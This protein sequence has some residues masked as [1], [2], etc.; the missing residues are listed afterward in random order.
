MPTL[1]DVDSDFGDPPLMLTLAHVTFTQSPEIMERITHVKAG[2]SELGLP[3][4]QTKHQS[5]I[6]LNPLAG[7]APTLRQSTFWWFSNLEKTRAVVVAAN[8]IVLYDANYGRFDDFID[9]IGKICA[10]VVD[11]AGAGCF[12]TSV[13]LRY[14]SGCAS[15]GAPSPY[16][17]ESLRGLVTDPLKIEHFHHDYNFWGVTEHEGKLVVRV[18][19][20]HGNQVVPKDVMSADIAIDAKFQLPK[21]IDAIQLDIH[22][23]VKK[24]TMEALT[25]NEVQTNLT[26]MRK[27]IK[28]AFLAATTPEAHKRW[29]M[30]TSK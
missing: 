18:K 23:T 27:N 17:S 8:S 13:A 28:T 6:A 14:V 26:V 16:L 25:V 2:L 11:V 21:T 5:N 20:V 10:I 30:T 19:T 29:K 3:V 12:L 15:D 24:K 4:A 1:P 7:T 9:R 22:E